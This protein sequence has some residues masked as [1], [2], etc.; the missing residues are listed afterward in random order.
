MK[1]QILQMIMKRLQMF[2]K[3]QYI[4]Q[5]RQKMIMIQGILVICILMIYLNMMMNQVL[6]MGKTMNCMKENFLISS[7]EESLKR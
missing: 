7:I 6:C 1:S 3:M 5:M 4:S 2:K